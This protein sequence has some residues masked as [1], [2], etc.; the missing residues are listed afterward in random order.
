VARGGSLPVHCCGTENSKSTADSLLRSQSCLPV[1]C[2]LL[3]L[4]L[5]S[6]TRPNRSLD[7]HNLLPSSR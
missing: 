3:R 5:S 2:G 6:Q 7:L 4:G 1:E